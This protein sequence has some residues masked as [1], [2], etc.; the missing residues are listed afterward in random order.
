MTTFTVPGQP[1]PKGRPRFVKGRVYT[2]QKTAIYEA[3]VAKWAK[4]AGVKKIEKGDVSIALDVYYKNKS[5]GDLDNVVKSV[6][7]GLN[8]VAW[9]DDKQV[10]HIDAWRSYDKGNPR[11][12]VDIYITP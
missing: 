9:A 7:D 11:V 2:P 3:K 5:H 12:E 4:V 6:M 8:K 1:I 10:C